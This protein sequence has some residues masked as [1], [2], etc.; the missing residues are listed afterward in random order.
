MP[1]LSLTQS[2]LD[3]DGFEAGLL[4]TSP[5]DRIK[6]VLFLQESYAE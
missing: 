2:I 1:P 5:I 4:L 6:W 3:H